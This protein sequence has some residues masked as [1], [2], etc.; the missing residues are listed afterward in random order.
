M[1]YLST[2]LRNDD[3]TVDASEQSRNG[4]KGRKSSQILSPSNIST[5]GGGGGGVGRGGEVDLPNSMPMNHNNDNHREREKDKEKEKER[6]NSQQK[7]GPHRGNPLP[8]WNDNSD[9][10][11][12]P[13]SALKKL[14]PR[15]NSDG[16][17]LIII[18]IIS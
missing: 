14:S 12:L 9:F 1:T 6:G 10:Q 13:T 4:P 8:E 16:I 5:K 17:I 7:R 11:D 18:I 2:S 15:N 3:V